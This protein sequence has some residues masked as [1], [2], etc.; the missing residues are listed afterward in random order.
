M[1]TRKK[2]FKWFNISVHES[3]DRCGLNLLQGVSVAIILFYFFFFLRPR[4]IKKLNNLSIH[5]IASSTLGRY[6]ANPVL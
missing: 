6:E 3:L 1:L 5:D 2:I 4:V